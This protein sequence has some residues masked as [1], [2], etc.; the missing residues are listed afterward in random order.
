MAGCMC[1][2]CE[3]VR[4]SKMREFYTISE[5]IIFRL[6]SKVKRSEK[7]VEKQL[8]GNMDLTYFHQIY[9]VLG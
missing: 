5:N 8:H 6:C 9:R 1:K 7:C 3:N 4:A 2:V